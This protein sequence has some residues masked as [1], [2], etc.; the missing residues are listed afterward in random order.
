MSC[1]VAI[2]LL[3]HGFVIRR[4]FPAFATTTH[5]LN[6]GMFGAL[7]AYRSKP[8]VEPLELIDF[9]TAREAKYRR[10]HAQNGSD[11]TMKTSLIVTL[12]GLLVMLTVLASGAETSAYTGVDRKT[13][14]PLDFGNRKATVFIFTTHDCPIANGYAPEISRIC[15]TYSG[16]AAVFLIHVDPALSLDDAR[17]HANEYRY[18]C[19]VLVDPQHELVARSNAKVT[20]QSAVFDV[21]G[22]LLYRGRI[23][24]LYVDF[25]KKR[26]AATTRD[27]RDAIDAV[28]AGKPVAMAETKAVGCFIPELKDKSK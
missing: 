7:A 18:T 8:G 16:K 1:K 20:P 11:D 13:Y 14:Q 23:D 10:P 21:S 15:E 5:E 3:H 2:V 19:P 6:E 12:G 22:K 26:N 24:D 9:P 25:G 27:L 28:L 4:Y 17:K